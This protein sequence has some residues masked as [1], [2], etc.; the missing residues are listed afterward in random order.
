[1]KI[2]PQQSQNN[3]RECLCLAALVISL[4]KDLDEV[5]I[6]NLLIIE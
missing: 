1:M 4:G 2:G 6:E 3:A 5:V